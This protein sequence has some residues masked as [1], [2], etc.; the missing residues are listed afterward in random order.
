MFYLRIDWKKFGSAGIIIGCF[1]GVI[2]CNKK[3]E[4]VSL[5]NM[6]SLVTAQV[7][8]LSRAKARLYKQA[9]LGKGQDDSTY[10]PADT[11]AWNIELDI[12]RQLH[13]V[14]KPINR[15]AYSLQDG[16]ADSTSNLTV[17]SF[18]TTSNIPVQYLNIFYNESL[19]K[20]RKI[21]A[22][23]NDANSLYQSARFLSMEF[24]HINNKAI[25]TSYSING[26]QK[27]VLGDSV[28]FSIRGKILVD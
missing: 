9:I 17:R 16:L 22:S 12:F 21:E 18:S 2:S 8:Y 27:M 5:Y 19:H 20:L 23:F 13:A 25:L 14:N 7:Q 1:A 6:D 28:T 24:Q 4:T 26:G 10:C 11:T 3:K 15:E